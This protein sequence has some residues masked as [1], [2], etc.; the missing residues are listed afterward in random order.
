MKTRY[1]KKRID[2][3]TKEAFWFQPCPKDDRDPDVKDDRF[4]VNWEFA[5]T[6]GQTLGWEKGNL[7]IEGQI[8]SVFANAVGD[9]VILAI[10][11]NSGEQIDVFQVEIENDNNVM[12]KDGV[13]TALVL[14]GIDLK[15]DILIELK[16]GKDYKSS[17][18]SVITPWDISF[19]QDGGWIKWT[20]PWEKGAPYHTGLEKPI[21]TEGLGGKV[22]V[23][24]SARD[25]VL[26]KEVEDFIKRFKDEIGNSRKEARPATENETAA[27]KKEDESEPPF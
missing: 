15:K 16:R 6:E 3:K 20:F 14:R 23:D 13:S 21:R 4:F 12:P 27:A 10:G 5:K 24:S 2:S 7:M 17:Y 9:S 22:K 11:V 1:W 26:L 25:E 19:S 18:G 8:E